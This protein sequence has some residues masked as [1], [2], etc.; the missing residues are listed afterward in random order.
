MDC[1]CWN[2]K[3]QEEHR[4]IESQREALKTSL[5]CPIPCKDRRV[6]LSQIL[7]SLNPVLRL[8]LRREEETLFPAFERLIGSDSGTLPLL[9]AQHDDLRALLD[10]LPG[11]LEDRENV[12][13]KAIQE[14][15]ETLVELLEDHEEKEA[16]FIANIL[17]YSLKPQ[18]LTQLARQFQHA[19]SV[20]CE[21]TER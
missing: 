19:A 14:T 9:R 4:A 15:G 20:F 6:H 1:A 8:H 16:R 17:E 11:L 2:R 5:E 10:R 7:C 13:W 12:S 21:E 3:I 18:E